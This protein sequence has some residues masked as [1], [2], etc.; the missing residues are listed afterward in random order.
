MDRAPFRFHQST[1]RRAQG[2]KIKKIISWILSFRFSGWW[3]RVH[4]KRPD[5]GGDG[6]N[7]GGQ[8]GVCLSVQNRCQIA[9]VCATF[10]WLICSSISCW[11]IF[12]S[13]FLFSFSFFL[14]RRSFCFSPSALSPSTLSLTLAPKQKRNGK[15]REIVFLCAHPSCFQRLTFHPIRSARNV[16]VPRRVQRSRNWKFKLTPA[17]DWGSGPTTAKHH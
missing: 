12:T 6:G 7:I 2:G 10:P 9:C 8:R 15:Q 1:N 13:V 4:L 16:G 14:P 3:V 17:D 5:S 11:A